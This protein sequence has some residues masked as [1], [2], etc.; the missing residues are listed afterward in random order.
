MTFASPEWLWGLFAVPLFAVLL[1][2]IRYQRQRMLERFAHKRCAA[3]ISL[4]QGESRRWLRAVM[5]IAAVAFVLLAL[6][7]PQWG[8]VEESVPT[9]GLDL[10]L[11]LDL[12]RSMLAEDIS[13]SRLIVARSVAREIARRLASDR[14]G[15]VGFA[16]Q[17][18]IFCPLTLDRGAL[19][20][21]LGAVDPSLFS[22][23]GTDLGAAID[24]A[25][26]MFVRQG[27]ARR[28]LVILSDGEDHEES[29]DKAVERAKL[30]EI[31]IYSI[32]LGT[33]EGAPIPLRD[34]AGKV[35][36]YL[37]D[38]EG[39]VVTTRLIDDSLKKAALQTGGAYVKATG[40]GHGVESVLSA[41]EDLERSDLAEVMPSR[42]VERYAWPLSIALLLIVAE[43]I[44]LDRRRKEWA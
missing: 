39:R 32:G 42:R 28:V 20:L 43:A 37:S 10:I 22:G 24:T 23:Q 27:K 30:E 16:G 2:V 17:S 26:E 38:A 41:L 11:A 1:L 29:V 35:S 8:E 12:S 40:F 6:A 13:P 4:L 5:L 19:E 21:Y 3:R 44:I 9:R 14:V 15:L 25:R 7:R 18:G 34:D 36:N 31:T 33:S